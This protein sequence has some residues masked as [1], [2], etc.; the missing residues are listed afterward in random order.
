[1]SDSF[2]EDDEGGGQ[3]WIRYGVVAVALVA[4]GAFLVTLTS[5]GPAQKPQQ[6]HTMHVVLPPPPPPPPP[7]KKP[8]EPEKPLEQPKTTATPL[9]KP[10]ENK[11][12]QKPNPAPAGAPLTAA[13]GAGSNA[14]GLAAGNGGGGLIGGGGGGGGG[15][16]RFG[17]YAGQIQAEIEAALQRDEKTRRGHYV[18]ALRLWLGATGQVQRAQVVSS[19][20]DPALDQEITRVI[21]ALSIGAGPPADMPQPVNLRVRARSG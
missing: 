9:S 1:V 12:A 18:L 11:P 2:D 3:R 6:Q 16:S 13:A 17:A 8:P 10:L 19:T 14:Y 15:G 5:G 20:G 4:A 7:L 21:N